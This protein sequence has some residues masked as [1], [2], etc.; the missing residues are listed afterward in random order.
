MSNAICNSFSSLGGPE[1]WTTNAGL[2]NHNGWEVILSQKGHW[3]DPSKGFG[4]FLQPRRTRT[5]IIFY[6]DLFR[7]CCHGLDRV[8]PADAHASH[9][10]QTKRISPTLCPLSS[11]TWQGQVSGIRPLLSQCQRARYVTRMLLSVT[12]MLISKVGKKLLAKA[13]VNQVWMQIRIFVRLNK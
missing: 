8:F 13:H 6:P 4:G 1:Y 2:S 9:H 12:K 3:T 5:S 11:V 7:C 10:N